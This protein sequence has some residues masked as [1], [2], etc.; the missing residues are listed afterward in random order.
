MCSHGAPG[1]EPVLLKEE[2]GAAGGDALHHAAARLESAQHPQQSGLARA[3]GG[4]EGSD[5]AEGEREGKAVQYGL[6][7]EADGQ[8]LNGKGH[9]RRP[10]SIR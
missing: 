10:L 8:I 4:G 1:E 9:P 5:A 2:G 7:S 6:L 3:G